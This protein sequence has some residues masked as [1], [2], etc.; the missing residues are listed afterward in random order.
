MKEL[1]KEA[2]ALT[3]CGLNRL[4]QEPFGQKKVRWFS[5]FLHRKHGLHIVRVDELENATSVRA[6][7]T[8]G[9][10]RPAEKRR[11][12]YDGKDWTFA[13]TLEWVYNEGGGCYE[14]AL[15]MWER[16]FC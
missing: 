4:A 3:A 15:G 16:D 12:V 7:V 8:L 1:L 5:A 14:W 11:C 9:V 6:V 13:E 10:R 2:K